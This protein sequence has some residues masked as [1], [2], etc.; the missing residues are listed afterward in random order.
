MGK[1][2]KT[3]KVQKKTDKSLEKKDYAIADPNKVKK[4]KKTTLSLE[5][6]KVD[7]NAPVL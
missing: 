1:L 4:E 6:K 3:Q 7:A 2:H 5:E